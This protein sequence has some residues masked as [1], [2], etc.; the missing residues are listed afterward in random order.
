MHT[1]IEFSKKLS[2]AYSALCKPLCRDLKLPQTA[3]DILM[4]LA[5]NPE[6]TTARDIVEIRKLKANL[7]SVNVDRLVAEGYLSRQEDER[8]RRKTH[9]LCTSKAA[10]V[11][12]KGH[13]LQ[14]QFVEKLFTGMDESTKLLF[15]NS[16]KQMEHN[17]DHILK[18]E[19]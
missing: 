2:A 7:V 12:P 1:G 3:F 11:I 19:V 18:N 13:L 5:N 15:L 16:M 17:L 6:Y 10:S 4:F 9:L 14:Q 8:D